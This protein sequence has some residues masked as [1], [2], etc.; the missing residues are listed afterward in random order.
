MSDPQTPSSGG[1]LLAELASRPADAAQVVA[2]LG[3][4]PAEALDMLCAAALEQAEAAPQQ[5]AAWTQAAGALAADLPAFAPQVDYARARLY[6]V[7]G[8]LDAAEEALR[9]AQDG[10]SRAGDDL[11]LA[12]SRL[13]LTQVLAVQGRF[14]EAEGEVG[15][16]IAT[17]ESRAATLPGAALRLAVAHNTAGTLLVYQER[18]AE[19]LAAFERG[20][21]LLHSLLAEAQASSSTPEGAASEDELETELAHLHLNEATARMALDEPAAAE[22]ALRWAAA[23]FDQAGDAWGRGR[24][25][26]NLG[27]LYVRTG[28][29]AAALAAF[30]AAASDLIGPAALAA[31]D[32]VELWRQADVLLLDRGAAYLALNMLP[33]AETALERSAAI[34]R[35]TE[36]PAELAQALYTLA[37]VRSRRGEDPAAALAEAEQIFA[38]LGDEYWLNRCRVARAA[39]QR[40]AEPQAAAALLDSLLAAAALPDAAEETAAR[41]DIGSLADARL[42]RLHLH[43]AAGEVAAAQAQA[44]RLEAELGAAPLPHLRLRLEHGRGLLAAAAGDA[45]EARRRYLAAIELAEAQRSALPLEEV[46][47]AYVSDKTDLFGDLIL[48]LLDEPAPQPGTLAAAF[49]LVER[50]RSRSLLER[51]LAALPAGPSEVD[52]ERAAR[53]QAL[54]QELNWLYNRLL[55]GEGARHA[56]PTLDREIARREALLQELEAGAAAP[57]AGAAPADLAALQRVLAADEQVVVYFTAQDELMAF[58][59][60][61]NDVQLFRHLCSAADAGAAVAELRRQVDRAELG[62]A[63]LSRRGERLAQALRRA[64]QELHALLWAPLEAAA[65]AP[66]LLIVPH[67]ALHHLPFHLLQGDGPALLERHELRYAPSASVAVHCRRQAGGSSGSSYRSLAALALDDSTIPQAMAEV[68]AA[69]AH[70]RRTR[71][72]Q[73]AQAGRD[74]LRRA[75]AEGDVLHIATHG[76]FRSDNPFFSSLKLADGWVDV[77][78]LYGLPLAARLV[79]LSACESGA[80]DVRGGDEVV[81]VARGFLGAGAPALVVSLWNVHDASA[82]QLMDRFYAAL[83]DGAG[84][85]A[86]LRTAQLAAAAQGQHPYFWAPYYTIG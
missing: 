15:A 17:L 47:A 4:A 3:F 64:A 65:V 19:A 8:D 43:A 9:R 56:G 50:A 24:A 32:D 28:A 53:T 14:A 42:L 37:V 29:Y 2:A 81:G 70:F 38:L 16:A 61:P 41:W 21:G 82:A 85:A 48:N 52:P 20:R 36:Q 57:L 26:A 54:R 11:A 12:R 49:A 75:A 1:T 44:G 51:L 40:I 25:Q 74:A 78:A 5:A 31:P 45:A 86:A 62:A 58:V 80:G 13:G 73:G 68:A 35:S 22:E 79:V 60:G 33:E 66:R 18:H 69:A 10:W 23:R 27:S 63:Y 83:A 30:D 59:V 6:L 84:P 76:L 34:F 72:Y 39:A 77:R 67:A 71:L 55:G 7:A 46:R